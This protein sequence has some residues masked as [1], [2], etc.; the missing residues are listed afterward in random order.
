MFQ[1]KVISLSADYFTIKEFDI[2]KIISKIIE[3]STNVKKR[4]N[5]LKQVSSAF[6]MNMRNLMSIY[7]DKYYL[8][9]VLILYQEQINIFVSFISFFQNTSN[10]FS[11]L[12]FRDKPCESPAAVSLNAIWRHGRT[13]LSRV[14][15]SCLEPFWRII[16]SY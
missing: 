2:I 16:V 12:L 6:A 1:L 13:P 4:A 9:R 11:S 10:I 15:P 14:Q 8:L 3:Q 5:T 7:L